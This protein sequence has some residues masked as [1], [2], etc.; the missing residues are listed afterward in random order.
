MGGRDCVLRRDDNEGEVHW[1]RC[2]RGG[3]KP[4]S[5]AL[6]HLIGE[7][8]LSG[9]WHFGSL[10]VPG[11]LNDVAG[12]F[13][14]RCQPPSL[15]RL[16]GSGSRRSVALYVRLRR[17]LIGQAVA[18]T[19][20]RTY[21]GYFRCWKLFRVSVDLPVVLLAGKGED[22]DVSLLLA[23]IAY[24]WGTSGL[25]A[26]AIAGHLAAVKY[27]H[28]QERGLKLFLRLPRIVDALNGVPRSRT[29][30]GTKSRIRRPVA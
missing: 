7:V 4:R 18:Q 13:S 27:F 2:C 21:Q 14:T 30:A 9:G 1:V 17:E 10:H 6:V 26:G 24:A 25:V 23:Y 16:R 29:V 5:G 11:V 20:E 12:G 28:R 8:E 19:S 22:I 15:Y 3:T